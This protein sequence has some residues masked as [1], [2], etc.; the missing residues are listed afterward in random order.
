MVLPHPSKLMSAVRFRYPAPCPV[1]IMVLHLFCNQVTAVR[2]CHGAPKKLDLQL[3]RESIGLSRR[4]QR[5][6]NSP[7]PPSLSRDRVTVIRKSHKLQIL[8]RFQVPQPITQSHY[9]YSDPE[10]MKL[11]CPQQDGSCS[12]MNGI[13]AVVEDRY[14]RVDQTSVG[15]TRVLCVAS[16]WKVRMTGT[17]ASYFD[18]L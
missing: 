7:G 11:S 16:G 15:N 5:D 4:R 8:V 17:I 3:N 13:K 12:Q 6:R 1:S 14:D 10:E 18:V 9:C 2:F